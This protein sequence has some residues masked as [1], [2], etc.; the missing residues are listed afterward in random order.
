MLSHRTMSHTLRRHSV[1][2]SIPVAFGLFRIL[3]HQMKHYPIG[4]R[5]PLAN[6]L[7][8]AFPRT[9]ASSTGLFFKGRGGS[10]VINAST[11]WQYDSECAYMRARV[12][13]RSC[14]CV[15][16]RGSSFF[17]HSGVLPAAPHRLQRRPG[18]VEPARLSSLQGVSSPHPTS[19]VCPPSLPPT[20]R[21]PK[22][23]TA[24]A[25]APAAPPHHPL[26]SLEKQ[27]KFG[28][29]ACLSGS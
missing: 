4:A 24:A 1:N 18:E 6:N 9:R 3:S 16:L 7:Y 22:S 28:I 29:Q 8:C 11:G 17:R 15:N 27:N 19:R 12:C 5:D 13:V 20:S 10:P 2:F 26:L 25:A 21:P 23:T 14:V